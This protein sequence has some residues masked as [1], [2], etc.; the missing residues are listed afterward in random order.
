M[1]YHAF[2]ASTDSR[3]D[4]SDLLDKHQSG[5]FK[6]SRPDTP[7]NVDFAFSI[8][9]NDNDDLSNHSFTFNAIIDGKSVS[10]TKKFGADTAT[11]ATNWGGLRANGIGSI[12]SSD[13]SSGIVNVN[14][15][16]NKGTYGN[17]IVFVVTMKYTSDMLESSL[18]SNM[19]YL[20]LI[21]N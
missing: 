8:H 5:F 19:G 21:I 11:G 7:S 14:F 10:I 2:Y 3:D 4:Y 17:T 15:G 9:N 16:W 6:C 12:Y 20:K 1:G 13:D 18:K